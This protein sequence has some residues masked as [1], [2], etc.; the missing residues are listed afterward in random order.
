[1]KFFS[2]FGLT[3]IFTVGMTGNAMAQENAPH[4]QEPERARPGIHGPRSIDQE[5]DHLTKDL[6]LTANQR[7]QVIPLLEQHHDKIQALFDS[8]VSIVNIHAGQMD[9]KKVIDFYARR[10]LPKFKHAA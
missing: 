7:K 6:E 10:V 5:L 1:M 9:Q 8:G 2:I 3:A 4:L